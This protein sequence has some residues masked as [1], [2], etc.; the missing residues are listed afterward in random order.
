MRK[1]S[2]PPVVDA[3]TRLL[4]LGSL[5]G[6]ASLAAAQYYAHPRNQ[7]WRLLSAIG[8]VELSALAY[9][10]RLAALQALGVGLWDVVASAQRRGSLDSDIREVAFNPLSELLATLPALQAVAFNGKTAAKAAPTLA[11]SGLDIL[12][13]PSSSPALTTPFERKLAEWQVLGRYILQ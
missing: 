9:P 2:F 10:Q 4:I 6:D 8:A 3:D 13:L 1:T 7:F 12:L 11:A 5:P